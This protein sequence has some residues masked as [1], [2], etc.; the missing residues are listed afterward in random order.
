MHNGFA[1]NVISLDNPFEG[2]L[3]DQ[4]RIKIATVHV[5]SLY[6][7][8]NLRIGRGRSQGC[9]NLWHMEWPEEDIT[10]D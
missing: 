4:T 1:K 8:V 9:D 6:R 2:Y 3:H 7:D 5:D 10:F